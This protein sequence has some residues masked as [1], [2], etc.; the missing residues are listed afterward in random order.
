RD[1]S[2]ERSP[3]H[4]DRENLGIGRFFPN[5]GHDGRAVTESIDEVVDERAVLG[6]RQPPGYAANVRMGGMHAAVDHGDSDATTGVLVQIH[7]L[8]AV[9]YHLSSISC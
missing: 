1:I 6:D 5:G 7:R 2:R 9:I 3:E 8:I 4:L